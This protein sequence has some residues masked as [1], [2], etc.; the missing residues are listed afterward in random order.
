MYLCHRIVQLRQVRRV[1]AWRRHVK[2]VRRRELES[3]VR[4]YVI[5]VSAKLIESAL[6]PPET[7]AR[8]R[9]G[10]LLQRQVHPLVPTVLLGLAR[11]DALES[12]SEARPPRR[13]LRETGRRRGRSKRLAVVRA[14]RLG[15]PVPLEKLDEGGADVVVRRMVKTNDREQI[16]RRGIHHSERVAE[17]AVASRELPLEVDAP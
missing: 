3:L 8:R 5:V 14:N 1:R 7:L 4:A 12:D 10:R 16:P 13:Q 15:Q 11:I 2:A 9:A 17:L 6:L